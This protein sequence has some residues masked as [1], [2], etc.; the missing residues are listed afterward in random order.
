MCE[1]FG[2]SANRDVPISFTWRGFIKRGKV[3]RDGWGV[4]WFFKDRLGLVKEPRPAPNS[5]IAKLLVN[6]VEGHIVISHVR[7]ASRGDVRYV[8]THPF[9]KVLKD[10]EWVFAHNGDVSGIMYEPKFRLRH[11][12]PTGSTDS[13]YAFCYIMD[14]LSKLGK[15]DKLISVSKV[16]WRLAKEIGRYGK[17]N[18]LLSDGTYLFAYMN[19]EG[20]LHYLLRHPPHVG[21]A[22][23]VDE[24]FKVEL[25]VIKAPDELAALIATE[26]LTTEKW[27]PLEPETLYVFSD[28]DLLLKV[29]S[30]GDIK[31]MLSDI[32]IKVL[33]CVRG[34]IHRLSLKSIADELGIDLSEVYESVEKLVLRRLLKQDS[35]DKVPLRHPKA[36]VYTVKSKRG[37]IDELIGRN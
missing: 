2:L 3:H 36:T 21:Y 7:W 10:R 32:D 15:T 22:E 9:V 8:N 24:D 27:V 31:V 18:F 34:S 23:L 14:N 33:E 13:E 4:A 37:F 6:G 20:T 12:H 35:R 26:P 19:V 16:L 11:Y 28:G 29:S 30:S 1:L 25:S 17:L 5:P